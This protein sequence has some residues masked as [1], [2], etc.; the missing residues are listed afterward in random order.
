MGW[1]KLGAKTESRS[2]P[3]DPE[4]FHEDLK[5]TTHHIET[6]FITPQKETA[7]RYPFAGTKIEDERLPF[8]PA[9]LVKERKSAE[10]GGLCM[11]LLL[12]WLFFSIGK[13]K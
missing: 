4:A 12:I 6:V 2:K 11:L 13:P 3:S 1:L 7:V 8:I 5:W 10:E 9:E